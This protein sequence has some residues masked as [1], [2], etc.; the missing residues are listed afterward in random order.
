MGGDGLANISQQSGKK[1]LQ[2][3]SYTSEAN[4]LVEKDEDE[5]CSTHRSKCG[6]RVQGLNLGFRVQGRE[7]RVYAPFNPL[8]PRLPR[9]EKKLAAE[10]ANGR[11]AMMAAGCS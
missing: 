5:W 11:L 2:Q 10:I 7:F 9:R 8:N 1:E 3:E 6:F 4:P